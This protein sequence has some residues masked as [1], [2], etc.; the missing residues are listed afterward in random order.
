MQSRTSCAILQHQGW[1]YNLL[2]SSLS[3][4]ATFPLHTKKSLPGP[5]DYNFANLNHSRRAFLNSISNLLH[6]SDTLKLK[7]QSC[8]SWRQGGEAQETRT[9]Q[10]PACIAGSEIGRLA[11]ASKPKHVMIATQQKQ[12]HVVTAPQVGV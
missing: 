6:M 3:L 11:Q 10:W 2:M 4:Q 7:I 1:K 12:H 5:I 8:S 9:L